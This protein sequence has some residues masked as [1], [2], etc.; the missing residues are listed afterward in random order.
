MLTAKGQRA[1]HQATISHFILFLLTLPF[2]K[3][4]NN[5]PT[6]THSHT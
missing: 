1:L 4:N 5:P 3:H 6:H 2:I